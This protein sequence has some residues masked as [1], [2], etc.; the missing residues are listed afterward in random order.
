MKQRTTLLK[1]TTLIIG[2]IVLT[3]SIFWLPSL[4][5]D[6]ARMNPGY[7]YLQFPVLI[8]LYVTTIPFFLALSEAWKLLNDIEKKNA[9][10]ERAVMSLARIK[11]YAI[12]ILL[13][14][15]LGMLILTFLHALHPGILALGLII[16]FAT[17]IFALFASL[18]QELL[19]SVMEIKLENDL[20][21]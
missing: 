12:A 8:G 20:T 16:I 14:Y 4:A 18:L 5:S 9:F 10:S 3:L 11:V 13:L 2:M 19:R 15:V 7:A 21:V 6:A 17:V 1:G